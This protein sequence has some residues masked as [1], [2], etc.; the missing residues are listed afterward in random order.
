[1]VTI[2]EEPTNY[3]GN[4]EEIGLGEQEKFMGDLTTEM[5]D[6]SVG[7]TSNQLIHNIWRVR[8]G[9]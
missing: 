6:K 4:L 3:Y 5:D 7:S 1:M 2:R 8:L 9:H